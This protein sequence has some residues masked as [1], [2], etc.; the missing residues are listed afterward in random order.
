[1]CIRW[2]YFG[3]TGQ[4]LYLPAFEPSSYKVRLT[5]D[6]GKRVVVGMF[7]RSS[8]QLLNGENP[9]FDMIFDHHTGLME[10][11]S[12]YKFADIEAIKKL[13]FELTERIYEKVQAHLL[14]VDS[15]ADDVSQSREKVLEMTIKNM[16][17]I[18]YRGRWEGKIRSIVLEEA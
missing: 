16:D 17:S 2:N 4:M 11:A 10:L 14:I 1:M 13:I 15:S 18:K 9:R 6:M 12:K 8:C 7:I 3:N 5:K